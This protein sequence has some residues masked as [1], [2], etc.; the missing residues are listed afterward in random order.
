MHSKAAVLLLFPVLP[1]FVI[2]VN[3]DAIFNFMCVQMILSLVGVVEWP[4]FEQ[5]LFLG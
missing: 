4:P 1:N 2:D 3:F 5:E